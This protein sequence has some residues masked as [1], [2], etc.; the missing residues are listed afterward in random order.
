[1]PVILVSDVGTLVI[2]QRFNSQVPAA[3]GRTNK[4]QDGPY[5]W[6]V[7]G[8]NGRRTVLSIAAT[9]CLIVLAAYTIADQRETIRGL[10]LAVAQLSSEN[11]L[12]EQTV[13]YNWTAVQVG[14]DSFFRSS[15]LAFL[16][17]RPAPGEDLP[18]FG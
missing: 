1:M 5:W 6:R 17:V 13:E 9:I 10:N 8:T 18:F 16:A 15:A 3:S 11:A 4:R 7:K 12:S 2:E 14:D